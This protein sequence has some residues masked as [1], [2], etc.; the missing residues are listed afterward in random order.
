MKLVTPPATAATGLAATAVVVLR[1]AG[2]L[3]GI[4]EH[5]LECFLGAPVELFV[6]DIWVGLAFSHM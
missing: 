4:G 1:L 5:A 2:L 3:L 6:A